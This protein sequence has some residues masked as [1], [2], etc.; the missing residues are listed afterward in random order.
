MFYAL[1]ASLAVNGLTVLYLLWRKSQVQD[2]LDIT[3]KNLVI[4]SNECEGWHKSY[5]F[6][7]TSS[8]DQIVRRD[9]QIKTLEDNNG[10]Y[11]EELRKTATPGVFAELLQKRNSSRVSGTP[12][13]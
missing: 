1:L 10:A 8:D 13:P 3:Q 11:L 6:L 2:E 5:D 12:K 4:R 7:K 9:A